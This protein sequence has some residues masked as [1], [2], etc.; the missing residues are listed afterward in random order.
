MTGR[1]R[2]AFLAL[3]AF[4][5]ACSP[6]ITYDAGRLHSDADASSSF[7]AGPPADAGHLDD[8]GTSAD[9]GQTDA[10]P[11]C[12]RSTVVDGGKWE[13]LFPEPEPNGLY[14]SDLEL[15]PTTGRLWMSYSGVDGPPGSGLVSTHLG[16][17]DDRGATWCHVGI[18]NRAL[19]LAKAD[20]PAPIATDTGHWNHEVSALVHD[21]GAPAD[22]RWRLVW[23]RYLHVDDGVPG[24]DDRRFEY[25]WIAQRTAATP[26]AL[27]TAPEQK[28]WSALFYGA[29]PDL[30]AWNDAAPGGALLQHLPTTVQPQCLLVTEPSM[31]VINGELFATLFCYRG[32]AQQEVVLLRLNRTTNLFEYVGTPLTTPMAQAIHPALTGFNGADLVM[33]NGQPH[34]LASPATDLYFGCLSFP[35]NL[36]TGTVTAPTLGIAATEDAGVVQTGPCTFHE[37]S[38]TGI[39]I[40]QLHVDGVQF[41]QFATS[42]AP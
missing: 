3:S 33:S 8:A 41:R 29:R 22:A 18:V 15:D 21:P 11:A 9:A 5:T 40:G 16:Y 13:V 23:H 14:D 42:V 31:V 30:E 20:Q 35:L 25:G 28:L 17:S 36:S 4:A 34:L 24:T 32:A 12:R 37:A 39:I 38:A 19:R 26:E 27:L 7:D 6:A 1:G 2:L 10:G